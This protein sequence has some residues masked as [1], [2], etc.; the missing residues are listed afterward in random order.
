MKAQYIVPAVVSGVLLSAPLAL[1]VGPNAAQAQAPAR[2]APLSQRIV[3]YDPANVRKAEGVHKGAG[4]L[5]FTGLLGSGAVRAPLVFL[6]RGELGPKSSIGQHFHNRTEE[7]FF[8]FD[9]DAQFTVDGRTSVVKGPAGVPVRLGHAHAVYNPTDRPLQWMNVSVGAAAQTDAFDLGDTREGA[10]LDPVP[11]FMSVRFDRA[12]LQPVQT[13]RGGS[14]AVQYRR[15]LEP[16][17]FLSPWSYVDHVVAGQGASF[18]P[19][20]NPTIA[21]VFYVVS[22][23]GQVSLGGETAPLKAGDAVPINPGEGATFTGSAQ[24]LEMVVIGVARDMGAK[25]T[26]LNTPRPRPAQPPR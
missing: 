3:H 15:V 21:E 20:D 4:Y 12:L 24:P 19:N 6:H 13:M 5:A 16:T 17:V 18:G 14:G 2:A 9:G 1:S 25:D 8:I 11:Q 22:G 10:P 7:V 23:T 26:L